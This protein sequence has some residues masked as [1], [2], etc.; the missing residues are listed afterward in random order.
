M[1]RVSE[2][3]NP[4]GDLGADAPLF[5][6]LERVLRSSSGPVNWELARQIGIASAA[7]EGAPDEEPTDADRRAFEDAV[8]LAEIHVAG[9]TGLDAPNEV[10][11]VE[12]V[13]RAQWVQR[14][15]E[16]LRPLVEPAAA[17]LGEAIGR[18][19]REALGDATAGPGFSLGDVL[20]QLSPLLLGAQVGSVLGSLAQQAL[21]QYDIALP[22]PDGARALRFVVANIAAFEKDWSLDETEFRTWVAIH[23]VTHRFEFARPWTL[24]YVRSLLDDYLSTMQIDVEGM[25][26]RLESIDPSNPDSM[27]EM[28]GSGEGLFGTVLD[29][30]QRL[31]LRRIEAFMGAA[32][33]YADH[34]VHALGARL[35]SSSARIEEAMR[36]YREGERVDPVMERMLGI[37]IDRDRYR[38]G[39]AFCD[40]VVER[41][42]E[43]LLGRM[44]DSAEALPSL[45]E[46]EE[47][48]L[49]LARTD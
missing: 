42:D 32:E 36:R 19:Q 35:L 38:L 46:L 45:P 47:P 4:F 7:T 8:R 40:T 23:E 5:R 18:A 28:L 49:W 3:E 10:A 11:V 31:K 26:R 43:T 21:G 25:Q 33:G 29:D 6:E 41:S 44:W 1:A 9:F 30:E 15:L 2:P 22:R 16:E 24:A 20:G 37:E 27:Q 14:N 13:R 48:S 39:R 12:P 34:V 17:K